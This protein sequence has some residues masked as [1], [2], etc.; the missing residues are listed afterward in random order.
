MVDKQI[1]IDMKKLKIQEHTADKFFHYFLKE[2]S[3]KI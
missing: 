1:Q 3:D 2:E